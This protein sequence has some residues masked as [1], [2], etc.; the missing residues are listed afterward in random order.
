MKTRYLE[1]QMGA[2][3]TGVLELERQRKSRAQ[4]HWDSQADSSRWTDWDRTEGAR[5]RAV[6]KLESWPVGQHEFFVP[7]REEVE[8]VLAEKEA[9]WG[10][11]N[12]GMP[13]PPSA[14]V[15]NP[16]QCFDS[17]LG[18]PEVASSSSLCVKMGIWMRRPQEDRDAEVRRASSLLD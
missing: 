3:R 13:K 12:S 7:A 5:S 14:P 11:A 2:Q 18:M 1:R 6:M 10:K 15:S 4:P 9:N 8:A 16:N 17:V